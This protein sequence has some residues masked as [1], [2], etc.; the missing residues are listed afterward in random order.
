MPR[1]KL[2]Q[3]TTG[4]PDGGNFSNLNPAVA[5][6]LRLHRN[7]MENIPLFFAIGLI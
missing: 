4:A 6:T 5:R 3:A 1:A 7:D 2:K